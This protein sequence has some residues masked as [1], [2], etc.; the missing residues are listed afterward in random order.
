MTFSI[1]IQASMAVTTK[2]KLDSVA[3][4]GGCKCD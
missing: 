4:N 3:V 2:A 1:A